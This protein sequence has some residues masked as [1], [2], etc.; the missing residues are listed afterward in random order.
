M[1]IPFYKK[2]YYKIDEDTIISII[3]NENQKKNSIY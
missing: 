2:S 3:E 1:I